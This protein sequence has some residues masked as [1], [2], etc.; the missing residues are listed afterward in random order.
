[1]SSQTGAVNEVYPVYLVAQRRSMRRKIALLSIV[2][3][4]LACQV[5]PTPPPLKTTPRPSPASPVAVSPP[6][7]LESSASAF[8][9]PAI[10]QIETRSPGDLPEFPYQAGGPF[11]QVQ[12]VLWDSSSLAP[13]ADLTLPVTVEQITNPQVISGLTLRQQAQLLKDG[14]II[15]HTQEDQFAE[16][17]LRVAGCYGQPYYLTA[18]VAAHALDLAYDELVDSLERQELHRREIAVVRATLDVVI[19]Y[20][21]LVQGSR[22]EPDTLQAAAYLGVGLRLLD[23]QAALDARIETAVGDQV[24]QIMAGRGEE[25]STLIPGYRD[26]FS[27]YQPAGRYAASAD[28]QN[29]FRGMSWFGRAVF[30]LNQGQP[31][32]APLVLTLALRQAHIDPS[33]LPSADNAAQDAAGQWAYLRATITFL[34]GPGPGYGPAEYAA[35]MDQVYS[36]RV[37]VVGL[38]DEGLWA[39]FLLYALQ[40]PPEQFGAVPENPL[41]PVEAPDGW[42]WMSFGFRLDDFILTSLETRRAEALNQEQLPSALDLMDVLSSSV[43]AEFLQMEQPGDLS[44]YSAQTGVLKEL[45]TRQKPETWQASAAGIRLEA[46]QSQLVDKGAA[47]P[48]PMRSPAWHYKDLNSALGAWVDLRRVDVLPALPAQ[49]QPLPAQNAPEPSSTP[50]PAFVEPN[51]EVFYRLALLAASLAEGLQE[52]G[53]IG[54]FSATPDP[55]SLQGTVKHMLDLSDRLE[56]LGDIAANELKGSPPEERDWAL[57]EAPLGP[58]EALAETGLACQHVEE[59]RSWAALPAVTGIVALNSD[60]GRVQY[61]ATGKVDRIYVLVTLED[62]LVVAQGGV[63]SYYEFPAARSGKLDDSDWRSLLANGLAELPVW[64][65]KLYLLEGSPVDVLAF[66]P[67]YAYRVT[68][69]AR[70]LNVRGEPSRASPAVIALEPGDRFT[71]AAGP[72][73]AEGFTWWKVHIQTADGR[74]LQGWLVENSAWYEKL[75]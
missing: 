31:S 71:I 60:A 26:D 61:A 34:S 32:R 74:T 18:D 51:P 75:Y 52:R 12:P 54:V 3:A 44:A 27:R 25:D 4:G 48:S 37:T 19:G 56:R 30:A 43:A 8:P 28:L 47:F 49:S 35:I 23:P 24:A 45:F 13:S 50:A 42:R 38:S 1:M 9:S 2:I 14:F 53:L 15:V 62:K 16:I 10:P 20:L 63:Y 22:L 58:Q 21:P 5:I 7:V 55:S 68:S 67:G 73:T 40:L 59:S 66:R 57:I 46:L 6:V 33:S 70:R 11:A 72:Q 36:P 17:R 29:Y 64:S 39:K 65:E 41:L 69:A